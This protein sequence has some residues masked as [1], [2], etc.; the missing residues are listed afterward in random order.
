MVFWDKIHPYSTWYGILHGILNGILHGICPRFYVNYSH[1]MADYED[2]LHL[3]VCFLV[4]FWTPQNLVSTCSMPG[5]ISELDNLTH[6]DHD[7]GG[8]CW[9]DN[10]R[11]VKNKKHIHTQSY[12]H[13]HTLDFFAICFLHKSPHSLWSVGPIL[14]LFCSKEKNL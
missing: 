14:F 13:T 8:R 7:V 9:P 1:L 12:T 4:C 3:E 2:G 6:D 11:N 5:L 10:I